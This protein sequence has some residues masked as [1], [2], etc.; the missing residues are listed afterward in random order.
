MATAPVS[1]TPLRSGLVNLPLPISNVL[2]NANTPPQNIVIELSFQRGLRTGPQSVYVGWTGM[3]SKGTSVEIDPTFAQNVELPYGGKVSVH[4]H[5]STPPA[6]QVFLEPLTVADWEIVETHAAFL[7]NWMVTQIRAVSPGNVIT[8]FPS[9][10]AMAALKVNSIEPATESVARV[11]ADCEAVIAPKVR[12]RQPVEHPREKVSDENDFEFAWKASAYPY[13]ARIRSSDLIFCGPP[14]QNLLPGKTY[15]VSVLRQP[16]LTG[17]S[18]KF[19]YAVTPAKQVNALFEASDRAGISAG[20]ACALEILGELNVT[21]KVAPALSVSSGPV[22]IRPLSEDDK[23][24]TKRNWT[25]LELREVG[26]GLLL[27]PSTESGLHNGAI[28]D[29]G[30][31]WGVPTR[32]ELG[33]DMAFPSSRYPRNIE[34]LEKT[35]GK[36]VVGRD[37]F[38]EEAA[39]AL[40]VGAG[41][42]LHGSR[43]CGKTSLIDALAKSLRQTRDIATFSFSCGRYGDK[44]LSQVRDAISRLVRAAAWQDP[45]VIICDDLD[46]LVPPDAE[47]GG[48]GRSAQI[49]EFF[50]GAF[51]AVKRRR[52]AILASAQDQ[53]AL[54]KRLTNSHFFELT[55]KIPSPD[56]DL[57]EAIVAN[58][59]Q[60]L[61]LSM[62]ESFDMAEVIAETEGYQPGDLWV[63]AE[64]VTTNS[65]LQNIQLVDSSHF[66]AAAKEF[67]PASLRGVQL[68]KTSTSWY[69]IG[70][71]AKAKRVLLETLEWPTKY[72]PIF[73]NCPLR[74][75]SGLL[76]YGFPGCGKTLL[77]SAV[78]SQCG[79]NFINVK[80]PEILNKYIGASEKSVRDL[81]DR[82]QAA[83]PCI[84]FFD[85]FDSIAPKRGHDST[86]VTDRVVNQL[87]TQMDGAEGLDGVYVLAATSRPD[88]I[89]SALLRPGRLD[90]AII[91][92]MPD[93]NDRCEILKCA[94]QKMRISNDVDLQKLAGLSGG[95]TGADLQALMYDA[96]LDAIHEYLETQEQQKPRIDSKTTNGDDYFQVGGKSL[97]VSPYLDMRESENE[98]PSTDTDDVIVNWTHLE[99]SLAGVKSSVPAKE[100]ARLRGIYRSF[101]SDR[102]GEMPSGTS[103]NE[104]GGRVT[105]G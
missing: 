79:L 28:V 83:K 44:S 87:L 58:A 51:Q 33:A 99:K 42:L 101:L 62:A 102:D 63:L 43:G 50:I 22:V 95:Y 24:K 47:H 61:N 45:A 49:A 104:V 34:N 4:L 55:K 74:L 54:H 56:K 65:S 103:S 85:E 36:P 98:K 97:D 46:R 57:R 53:S 17:D 35:P 7:E 30:F 20:L 40:A 70:G 75:R 12:M 86:G 81:F 71:L 76:L 72:A 93:S 92:D 59:A 14:E 10:T 80:G 77:A 16:S 18:S 23:V 64:R 52:V 39:K 9:S 29:C 25:G 48:S 5:T 82:A 100:V 96:Y 37:G 2:F 105:L 60:H 27:P 78:A 38:V 19:E 32:T 26:N 8:V 1:F 91:C 66:V 90:K 69:D 15:A 68:T 6:R 88:L 13:G 73:A 3:S 11:G 21:L 31:E 89:D 84:L 41:V 94:S 67:I